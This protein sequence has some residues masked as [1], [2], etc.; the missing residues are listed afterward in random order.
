MAG[1]E[2]IP[3][4]TEPLVAAAPKSAS[5]KFKITAAALCLACAVAGYHA[6]AA[7]RYLA[8]STEGNGNL[9]NNVVYSRDVQ[10]CLEDDSDYCLRLCGNLGDKVADLA[11]SS[12]EEP[13]ASPR[14]RAGVASMAWRS[15]RRFSTDAP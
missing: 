4:E 13:V 6:P 5:P 12:G 10:I 3:K 15:T 2:T 11:R 7:V 1:Y 9:P 14:H 8:F